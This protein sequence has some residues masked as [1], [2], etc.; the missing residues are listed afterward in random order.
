MA[1]VQFAFILCF[2]G[3]GL[4]IYVWLRQF[5]DDRAAGLA[6][7]VYMF[8]PLF[9]ATVYVR[10]SLADANVLAALPFG[11]AGL[12]IYARQRSLVGAAIAVLAILWLWRAQAGLALFATG[13]LVCYALAVERSW[14]GTLIVAVASMAGAITLFPI[15]G[16][17]GSPP[18]PFGEHF[19]DLYQFFGVT[20]ATAPSVAGWQDRF[21]F[22]LGFVAICFG[23]VALWGWWLAPKAQLPL[24]TSRL[25][26]FCGLGVAILLLLSLAVSAPL[27]QVTGAE[28]LL[29][30]PWQVLL[31]A[32][33]L[34]AA[35]AGAL[36][37]VLP[38]LGTPAYWSALV[39]ITVL[40]SY[41]Y[42]TPVYTQM[43]PPVNFFFLYQ[44]FGVT[45]ETAP[46]MVG[47]QDRY[48]FQLG[49]VAICFVL[50]ALW[51]GGWRPK[52]NCHRRQSRLLAFCGLGVAILLLLSL[53]V[54]APLW[55]VTGAERLLTYPWQVLLLG[56]PLLAAMA[57][58]LP[59]VL[60]GL[61]AP[62]YWSALVTITVLGSY[63]YLTP[64]YTQMQPPAR[65][66]AMF[67]TDQ[68]VILAAQ[69]SETTEPRA[70]ELTVTWQPLQPLDFDYNVFFQAIAGTGGEE[71]SVAQL[72]AQPLAGARP[73][74]SWRPGEILTETY[75]LDLTAATRK[76]T[77]ALLLRLL[78]L[79]R[80]SAAAGG[81][82]R[83]R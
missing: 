23:L 50:V 44:F 76:R 27:W 48:P 78:R 45:W 31:L 60:P 40:A 67:G 81:R 7:L 65:P 32:A 11:L 9:L 30:Y 71:R 19:V 2:I 66:V 61:G 13:L 25:L 4:G 15:W 57:G 20:W 63:S 62:A 21:P 41:S 46:S 29:T 33:P 83:G 38:G 8:L 14:I 26:A 42:L 6:G 35:L 64:A 70:A 51:G 28:R 68:V 52:G 37:V 12:A 16:Q 24:G 74:T 10:G 49:F 1:A 55:Q 58:A 22:Q 5:F 43:Q 3:G 56:A 72:D 79:A 77:L 53:A 69:L 39:T 17:T 73:A 47:W 36:P 18:V 80:R 75:R 54:S 34:L 82:R 59:V